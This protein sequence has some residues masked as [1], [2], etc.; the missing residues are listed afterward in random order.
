[1]DMD[2]SSTTHPH[3]WLSFS[4]SN[5]YNHG[6]LEALSSSSSGHHHGKETNT[7]MEYL[8]HVLISLAR[9]ASL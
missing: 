4:L 2:M 6:L 9:H 3:H 7:F 8:D 5:N 1:M